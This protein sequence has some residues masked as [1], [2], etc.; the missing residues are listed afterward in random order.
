MRLGGGGGERVSVFCCSV[1][2]LNAIGSKHTEGSKER[3]FVANQ[4][5]S[6]EP[7]MCLDLVSER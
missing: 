1:P 7:C 5:R 4:Q 6:F 3:L 2:R